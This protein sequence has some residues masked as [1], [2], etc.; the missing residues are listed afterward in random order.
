MCTGTRETDRMASEEETQ[1]TLASARSFSQNSFQ[2]E[3]DLE[4]KTGFFFAWKTG[5]I[6]A[7]KAPRWQDSLGCWQGVTSEERVGGEPA[8]MVPFQNGA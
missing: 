3:S 7:R 8:E 4:C 6:L 1:V 2:G 5:R